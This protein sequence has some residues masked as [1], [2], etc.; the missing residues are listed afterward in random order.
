[1][2]V[3]YTEGVQYSFVA[4]P[5]AQRHH[6]VAMSM[7]RATRGVALP[8]SFCVFSALNEVIFVSIA[9]ELILR[10]SR[11]HHDNI[12]TCYSS[13]LMPAGRSDCPRVTAPLRYPPQ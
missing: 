9:R 4:T 1:M 13:S 3:F 2:L 8:I 11:S 6:S 5:A 7:H 10:R 12:G